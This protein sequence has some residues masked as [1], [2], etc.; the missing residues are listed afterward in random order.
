MDNIDLSETRTLLYM[1]SWVE[2]SWKIMI[3]IQI[4]IEIG[5]VKKSGDLQNK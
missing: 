5:I 2:K 1:C 4:L 3:Y